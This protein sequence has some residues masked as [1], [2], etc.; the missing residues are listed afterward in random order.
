MELN[1]GQRRLL[2]AAL[3]VSRNGRFSAKEV[4]NK[5]GKKWTEEQVMNLATT[6]IDHDPAKCYLLPGYIDGTT[7]GELGNSFIFTPLAKAAVRQMREDRR[8]FIFK[9]V[10]D[11]FATLV[12]GVLVG[13]SIAWLSSRRERGTTQP[14][15]TTIAV[16]VPASATQ[17]ATSPSP[18]TKAQP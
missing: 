11:R 1:S 9:W 5:L 10:G 4:A 15:S 17:P 2:K 13:V 12:V 18:S 8:T 3:S 7:S 16:S 6:L 14:T